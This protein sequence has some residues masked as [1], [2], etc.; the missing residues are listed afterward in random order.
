MRPMEGMWM[1]TS[2]DSQQDMETTMEGLEG[3][4]GGRGAG[5]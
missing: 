1:N 4:A 3:G 5:K 2:T